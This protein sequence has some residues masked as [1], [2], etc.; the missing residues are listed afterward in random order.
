MQQN[1]AKLNKTRNCPLETTVNK[2]TSSS[3]TQTNWF[4]NYESTLEKKMQLL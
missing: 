4:Q 3:V 2:E 1:T